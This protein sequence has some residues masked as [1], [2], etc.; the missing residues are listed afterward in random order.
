[1]SE[2]D[3]QN[4]LSFDILYPDI[5][6]E[7]HIQMQKKSPSFSIFAGATARGCAIAILAILFFFLV[8]SL[9]LDYTPGMTFTS[10]ITL[11]GFSLA[12]SYTS[13]LLRVES[14]PLAARFAL[15]FA[16]I[17]AAYFFVLLATT[18][19]YFVGYLLYVIVYAVYLGISLLIRTRR[20]AHAS[21]PEKE[22]YTNRF[23]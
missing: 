3:L 20:Q 8:A 13:L 22:T 9:S 18:E 12:V 5:N 19:A 2:K 4:P 7:E 14:I 23:S 16:L 17:G 11:T 21:P 15:H 6:W 10:F 1:M